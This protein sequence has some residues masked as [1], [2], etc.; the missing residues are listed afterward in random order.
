MA[1]GDLTDLAGV[2]AWLGLPADTG[3]S[4][5]LLSALITAV[6]GWITDYLGRD[7]TPTSYAEIYD[8]HGG[9]AML[10]RQAPITAVQSVSFCGQTLTTPADPVALT[11][12][13]LFDD[14]RLSLLGYC[15]P[16][17]SPVVVVYTAGYAAIPPAIAQAATELAGEAFRRRDRI[18]QTSKSL[19]GQETVAF[20]ATDMNASIKAMLAGYRAVAPV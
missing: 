15:F 4:D 9:T 2:K 17:R 19:G 3:A 5:A 18:G 13:F 14:R 16:Q 7:L 1:A 8:G 11:P 6:S 12:G 20:S 10:L